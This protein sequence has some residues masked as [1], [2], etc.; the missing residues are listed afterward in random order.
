MI[1]IHPG[2]GSGRRTGSVPDRS[3]VEKSHHEPWA[4]PSS[5]RLRRYSVGTDTVD[6]VIVTCTD[7][8]RSTRNQVD[9]FLLVQ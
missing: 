8:H 5:D 4:D 6:T 9:S 3:V 1:A 7:C 2:R